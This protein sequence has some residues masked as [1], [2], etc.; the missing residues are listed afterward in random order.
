VRTV[1]IR[2]SIIRGTDND[3][4][5]TLGEYTPDASV[6]CATGFLCERILSD[7]HSVTD[8]E[9]EA[10]LDRLPHGFGLFYY[11]LIAGQ[12]TEEVESLN[13]LC[14]VGEVDFRPRLEQRDDSLPYGDGDASSGDL[15]FCPREV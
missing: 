9:H 3:I 8:I 13:L 2:Q 14:L 11:S 12:S 10:Y 4:S 1:Q 6:V 7:P 5:R 15:A